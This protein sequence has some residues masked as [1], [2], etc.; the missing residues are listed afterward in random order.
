MP[1]KGEK[2]LPATVAKMNKRKAET[3]DFKAA[4][5]RA[6][7]RH[8]NELDNATDKLLKKA[9]RGDLRATE[10]IRDTL[11]GKPAQTQRHEGGDPNKPVLVEH[12]FRTRI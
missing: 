10:M 5:S 7:F 11:D 4:L 6:L 1:R 3:L 2:I 12:A 8:P 9:G